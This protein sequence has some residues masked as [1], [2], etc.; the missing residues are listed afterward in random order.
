MDRIY[1]HFGIAPTYSTTSE[2][3]DPDDDVY[4]STSRGEQSG[5]FDIKLP[6]IFHRGSSGSS[7]NNDGVSRSNS[8]ASNSNGGGST[9][10]S[11]KVPTAPKPGPGIT[12]DKLRDLEERVRNRSMNARGTR[13]SSSTSSTNISQH[14]GVNPESNVPSERHQ[15]KTPQK[16]EEYKPF[17]R[18]MPQ[19]S[20]Y[21]PKVDPDILNARSHNSQS[22]NGGISRERDVPEWMREMQEQQE[23][24]HHKLQSDCFN[25]D[26]F[27]DLLHQAALFD[28]QD[29]EEERE[30]ETIIQKKRSTRGTFKMSQEG[31]KIFHGGYHFDGDSEEEGSDTEGETHSSANNATYVPSSSARE[32][33]T[34]KK[35]NLSGSPIKSSPVRGS[36]SKRRQ[37]YNSTNRKPAASSKQSSGNHDSD[38]DFIELHW[39]HFLPPV[40]HIPVADTDAKDASPSSSRVGQK[41]KDDSDINKSP[42]AKTPASPS[43]R[44]VS[45]IQTD[46]EPPTSS[47][48][49]PTP[50]RLLKQFLQQDKL[51]RS[52][53]FD[54]DQF[55][56]NVNEAFS[57]DISLPKRGLGDSAEML[58]NDESIFDDR[59]FNS[60]ATD[61]CIKEVKHSK[62]GSHA[63][64]RGDTLGRR[65]SSMDAV[66]IDEESDDEGIDFNSAYAPFEAVSKQPSPYKSTTPILTKASLSPAK[67]T[68]VLYSSAGSG[69]MFLR[70]VQLSPSPS[71]ST[72][73]RRPNDN[74]HVQE[75]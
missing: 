66:I 69:Q 47:T 25:P 75:V 37:E 31:P 61:S 53:L 49:E 27:A 12:S 18:N 13:N 42:K 20:I 1:A 38:E 17:R 50:N 23:Q 43:S 57:T 63:A 51:S 59:A 33:T 22:S 58:R 11:A 67:D 68:G 36:P 55:G 21:R 35:V 64:G 70:T 4:G 52:F 16:K 34:D 46:V 7:K 62:T 54:R 48:V 44:P 65:V 74:V 2:H 30:E 10:D 40:K 56:D 28:L 9:T 29:E 24:L 5:K 39:D 73:S 41:A 8:G 3:N 72:A 32:T 6:S 26:Y 15:P 19:E 71:N 45:P 14:T 60:D